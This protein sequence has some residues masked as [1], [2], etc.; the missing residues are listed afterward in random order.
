M[1]IKIRKA[2]LKD[3][4]EIKAIA[5]ESL[6]FH[7]KYE[8]VFYNVKKAANY[9]NRWL[10]KSIQDKKILFFVAEEKDKVCGYVYGRLI[11]GYPGY[12]IGDV[13]D[14]AVKKECQGRSIGKKLLKQIISAFKNKN[15][16]DIRLR[17]YIKNKKALG[18]YSSLGFKKTIYGLKKVL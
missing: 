10:K 9:Y 11:L 12:N 13:Y 5:A 1:K 16:K 14:I 2:H 7:S 18:L 17:V 8:P 4:K 15:C 3:L 6:E